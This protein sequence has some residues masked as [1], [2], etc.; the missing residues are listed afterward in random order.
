MSGVVFVWPIMRNNNNKVDAVC[1]AL[2]KSLIVLLL[3]YV[4][5]ILW[6]NVCFVRGIKCSDSYANATSSTTTT[7]TMVDDVRVRVTSNERSRRADRIGTRHS[8]SYLITNAGMVATGRRT[9]NVDLLEQARDWSVTDFHVDL[10]VETTPLA[11]KSEDGRRRETILHDD[12]YTRVCCCY[13]VTNV[14][15]TEFNFHD[16][17]DKL[18]VIAKVVGSTVPLTVWLC[19]VETSQPSDK[20]RTWWTTRLVEAFNRYV[21]SMRWQYQDSVRVSR[22]ADRDEFFA[23]T[24]YNGVRWLDT[25][26]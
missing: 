25:L 14:C 20:S 17:L 11:I 6:R 12:A 8:L 23:T 7:T 16:L 21:T 19:D 24:R 2:Y 5:F 15:R 13:A 26:G 10:Y 3:L 4:A 18:A 1:L 9:L 22:V